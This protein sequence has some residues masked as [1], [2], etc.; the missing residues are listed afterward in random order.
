LHAVALERAEVI[1][2]PEL[3]AELLEHLPVLLLPAL[4]HLLGQVVLQVRGDPVVVDEGVVD[5]EEEDDALHV[6]DPPV[7]R[8]RRYRRASGDDRREAP[9]PAPATRPDA[10]ERRGRGGASPPWRR[11]PRGRRPPRRLSA[12]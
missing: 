10:R 2:V 5:V 12:G 1:R 3:G 4:T 9:P 7:E 11:Q 6:S 8:P